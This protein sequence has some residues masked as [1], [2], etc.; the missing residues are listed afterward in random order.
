M[1]RELLRRLPRCRRNVTAL[2]HYAT[3]MK[4]Y[5]LS[6]NTA[7]TIRDA[8]FSLAMRYALI[9]I[10]A[11]PSAYFRRDIATMLSL[12]SLIISITPARCY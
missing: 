4:E 12:A 1:S 6:L 11:L 7:L 10:R 3:P 2:F 5:A 8:A 9:L